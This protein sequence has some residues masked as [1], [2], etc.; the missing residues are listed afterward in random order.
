[1]DFIGM[2]MQ[3]NFYG[4]TISKDVRMAFRF[5]GIPATSKKHQLKGITEDVACNGADIP[6]Q[7]GQNRAASIGDMFF[8]SVVIGGANLQA[9]KDWLDLGGQ[10]YTEANKGKLTIG[11]YSMLTGNEF[12]QIGCFECDSACA[13]QYDTNGNIHFLCTGAISW[14]AK[15][16]TLTGDSTKQDWAGAWNNTTVG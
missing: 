11:M 7:Q 5:E 6:T 1:M 15:C 3:D 4:P 9:T 10:G 16:K 2:L 14:A 12:Q 13:V 8:Q